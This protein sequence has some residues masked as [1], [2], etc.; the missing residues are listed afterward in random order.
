MSSTPKKH[1]ERFS[2]SQLRRPVTDIKSLEA[3]V[4][5]SG[6]L[7]SSTHLILF[8]IVNLP[9]HVNDILVIPNISFSSLISHHF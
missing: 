4:T 3:A 8:P 6:F 5:N 9:R 7:D 1:C 2:C